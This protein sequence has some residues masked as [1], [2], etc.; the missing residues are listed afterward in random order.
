MSE[1]NATP[2]ANDQAP[3]LVLEPEDTRVRL[4]SERWGQIRPILEAVLFA[5]DRPLTTEEMEPCLVAALETGVH[6]DEIDEA[7]RR[8]ADEY[9]RDTRGFSLSRMA[10]GWAFHTREEHADA[11]RVLYHRKPV[12]LSRAALEVLAIVAY[13]QPCTRADVDDIRGVDSS[14]TLRQLLDRELIRILG[15]SDD[16]GRPLLYGTSDGFLRFFGLESL[17]QLPTLRDFAELDDVHRVRV[18]TL[19]ETLAAQNAED[20]PPS[21]SRD[22]T[23]PEDH[24]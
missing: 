4:G 24:G 14:S 11:I 19:E 21:P 18:Q 5:A 1:E 9:D 15:K 12:R 8:I 7:L 2:A 16:V 3:L 22:G 17:A 13:R 20:A 6:L 23:P 10:G